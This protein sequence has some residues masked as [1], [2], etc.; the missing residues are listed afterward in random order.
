M[1]INPTEPMHSKPQSITKEKLK[2]FLPKGTSHEVTNNIINMINALENDTGIM[3]EYMEEKVLANINVLKEVKVSLEE[4]VDAVKYCSL[5][6][7]LS[8]KKA[9]EI[10]FPEK[11]AR[12]LK[13]QKEKGEDVVNIDSHVSNYNSNKIV[14][15][16]DTMMALP[17]SIEY[18]P[19][20][21]EAMDRTIGVMRGIG[22]K[23]TDR[24]SVHVQHLAAK[25]I[26]EI[27]KVPEEESIE[28]KI[29][30]TD[31]AKR[32]QNGLM[33]Q[34]AR[35]ADIQ[36]A[37]Y[38]AGEDISSIQKLGINTDFVEADTDE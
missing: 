12:L 37:K 29:G 36:V 6:R 13:M 35:V 15:K 26:L 22:A 8:N 25:T 21:K 24:V 7:N 20:F 30:M 11:M 19:A 18:A 33:E 38:E 17:P 2:R 28:L 10:V 23:P 4:Y 32:V 34:L 16:L 31:D 5:K 9:W 3:Q 27:A 1:A 14:V